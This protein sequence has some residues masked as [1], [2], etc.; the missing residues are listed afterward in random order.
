MGPPAVERV[1]NRQ[2]SARIDKRDTRA[3]IFFAYIFFSPKG[4]NIMSRPNTMAKDQKPIIPPQKSAEAQAA[5]P[6]T[7]PKIRNNIPT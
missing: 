5:K 6:M 2:Q 3:Y 1:L 4:R 7:R